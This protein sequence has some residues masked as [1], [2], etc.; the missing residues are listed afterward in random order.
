MLEDL[1]NSASDAKYYILNVKIVQ[2][3]IKIMFVMVNL[4]IQRPLY[5]IICDKPVEIIVVIESFNL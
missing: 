3:Y 2:E 5:H 1:T 4:D